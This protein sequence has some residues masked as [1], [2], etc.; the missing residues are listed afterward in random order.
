MNASLFPTKIETWLKYN[1]R[2]LKK[3]GI[4]TARLDCLILL[5]DATGKDRSWLLANPD[6]TVQ[7]PALEALEANILR[8]AAHEP[9]AYIRGKTEFYGREFIINNHVLEPR[10]ESETMI[11][12][13]KQIMN[14]ERRMKNEELK[15]VDV[16][17]GSGAL[18]ITAKLELPRANLLA[19]DIDP[20][21]IKIAHQNAQNLGANINFFIGNLLEPLPR[22]SFSSQH[23]VILANLPYVPDNYRINNAAML[24]PKTAIFGGSDGLYLYRQLFRQAADKPAKYILTESLP[25]QHKEL[26]L[27]AMNFGYRQVLKEDFIQVFERSID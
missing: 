21:C 20:K 25:F 10:P 15:I 27:I 9:L 17:T 1:V 24:E 4:G 22:S 2:L 3:A 8:R 11:D 14:E 23:S 6:L 12:L 16:G 13:L 18:A 5:E 26:C 19:V 7:G